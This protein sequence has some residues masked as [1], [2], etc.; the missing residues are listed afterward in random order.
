MVDLTATAQM[1]ASS[2]EIFQLLGD[3][4]I[5]R[6]TGTRDNP[7]DWTQLDLDR[8]IEEIAVG[9]SF[10]PFNDQCACF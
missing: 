7:C 9:D 6:F 10:Y 8:D 1:V 2:S 3:S 4:T 5:K